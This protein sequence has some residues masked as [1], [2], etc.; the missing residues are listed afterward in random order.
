LVRALEQVAAQQAAAWA[1]AQAASEER[2]L[3][4]DEQWQQRLAGAVESALERTL[5][6]HSR[7]LAEL[8]KQAADESSKLVEQLGGLATVLRDTDR[9]H[10]TA[11]GRIADSMTAQVQALAR[12]QEGEKQLVRLQEVLQQNLAALA[13]AGAFEEAVHNL[14]AAIHLLT[15]RTAGS[16]TESAGRLGTRPGAAA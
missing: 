8:E 1:K 5:A 14:T 7:R 12:L 10:Q 15:A 3:E 6:A 2:R 9:E 13:G 16:P 4:A 11:L